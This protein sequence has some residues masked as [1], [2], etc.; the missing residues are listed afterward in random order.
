MSVSIKATTKT[1]IRKC[2]RHGLTDHYTQGPTFTCVTCTKELTKIRRR[3][4]K[5]DPVLSEKERSRQ[6]A[7][8]EK[9]KKLAKDS[10][11]SEVDAQATKVFEFSQ[12]FGNFIKE[13]DSVLGTWKPLLFDRRPFI[14]AKTNAEVLVFLL[15]H[16][17]NE[18]VLDFTKQLLHDS[19]SLS[20]HSTVAYRTSIMR[21]EL[22][23]KA[24]EHAAQ[25]M[26]ELKAK[27][28]PIVKRYNQK[29]TA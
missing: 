7:N 26:N 19:E 21:D 10:G 14:E 4:I 5:A 18:L 15:K 28:L 8:Y 11:L 25:E 9:R 24:K 22:N 2:R 1:T 20:G 12:R 17:R 27:I 29:Q 16:R 6:K 13:I 23:L 3:K